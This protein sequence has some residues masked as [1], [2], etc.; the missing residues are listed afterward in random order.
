M[1]KRLTAALTAGLLILSLA[2]CGENQIPEMTDE[3][4]RIVGEYAAIT[5]MRYDANHR[6]RL[7]DYTDMLITPTPEPEITP[8]PTP[9]APQGMD[10]VDDT[11]VIGPS[12]GTG[13]SHAMEE[14]LELPE[15][16]SVQYLGAEFYDK[17]P[18]GDI[19]GFALTATTGK[20]LLVLNFS[21]INAGEQDVAVDILSLDAEFN[22]TVNGDYTRRALLT[23][24][25]NDLSTYMGT[26]SG[27]GS[28]NTVLV[29]EV[30][31]SVEG[32]LSSL[33]LNLKNDQK[34]YT[35]QFF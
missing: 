21:L 18:E 20:K 9:Q 1:R 12:G 22:I 32:N 25:D 16:L 13:N 17:Y 29:I 14:V 24:L 23:M 4:L 33:S 30:D 5:L 26:I 8:T 15:G 6:S 7:V 35:I 34:T 11:L 3:E 2:G 28:V 19:V 10:P 27:T 31:E